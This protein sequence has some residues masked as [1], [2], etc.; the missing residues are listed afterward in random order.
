MI[1]PALTKA[2]VRAAA[3]GPDVGALT[4]RVI[5][6][7]TSLNEESTPVTLSALLDK[8]GA[9]LVADDV[10]NCV[11]RVNAAAQPARSASKAHPWA[12]ARRL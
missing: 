9:L 8:S 7:T 2:R 6:V 11:W 3:I 4:D 10:G 1:S 5:G 12:A